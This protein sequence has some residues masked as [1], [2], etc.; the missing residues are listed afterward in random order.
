MD[1][2]PTSVPSNHCLVDLYILL[3][4]RDRARLAIL[5]PPRPYN[6]TTFC[7]GTTLVECK[8]AWRLSPLSLFCQILRYHLFL[9]FYIGRDCGVHAGAHLCIANT[10]L[11]LLLEI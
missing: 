10:G 3:A 11:I 2:H 8:M 1:F 4:C 5:A 6:R 9:V 7:G